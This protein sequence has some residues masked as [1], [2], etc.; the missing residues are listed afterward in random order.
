MVVRKDE[1]RAWRVS[2]DE[3]RARGYSLDTW[4]P[5]TGDVDQNDSVAYFGEIA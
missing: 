4:T 3:F 2:V 5:Y 1:G